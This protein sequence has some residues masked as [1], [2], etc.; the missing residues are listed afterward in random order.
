MCLKGELCVCD[1]KHHPPKQLDKLAQPPSLFEHDWR[2]YFASSQ[3]DK[4]G[5][6]IFFHEL[7]AGNA[8]IQDP[9]LSPPRTKFLDPPLVVVRLSETNQ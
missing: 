1:A 8:W 7:R 4:K 3:T 2:P 5:P 6:K 9:D